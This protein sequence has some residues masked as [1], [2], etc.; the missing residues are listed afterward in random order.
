MV[1]TLLMYYGR[2]FLALLLTEHLQHSP[3]HKNNKY[4]FL[5]LCLTNHRL[6]VILGVFINL[7]FVGIKFF[8]ASLRSHV[9]LFF[10][11][12]IDSFV[13]CYVIVLIVVWLRF[14]LNGKLTYLSVDFLQ[15][16]QWSSI[17][18]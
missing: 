5:L 8:F 13:D 12:A 3:R 17:I 1:A 4:V 2:L 18:W 10:A 15:F 16:S 6:T 11:D 9:N 14:N 7:A